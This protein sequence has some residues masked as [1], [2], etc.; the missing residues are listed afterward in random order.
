MRELSTNTMPLVWTGWLYLED[1]TP[2]A[3]VM[4]RNRPREADLVAFENWWEALAYAVTVAEADADAI[5]R[6]GPD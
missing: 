3:Y 6:G 4:P 5:Y 2:C 1:G